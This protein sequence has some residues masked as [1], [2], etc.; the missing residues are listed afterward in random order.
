VS[1][2]PSYHDLHITTEKIPRTSIFNLPYNVDVICSRV[3]GW[4]VW[5]VSRGTHNERLVAGEFDLSWLV[6]DVAGHVIVDSRAAADLP[7]QGEPPPKCICF[8]QWLQRPNDPVVNHDPECP[9]SESPD[10]ECC[11][12]AESC[13]EPVVINEHGIMFAFDFFED[14]PEELDRAKAEGRAFMACAVC[15]DTC[16]AA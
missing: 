15:D 1:E 10:A 12:H 3:A 16:G 11:G 6:L 13:H 5:D 4:Q 7:V 2:A 14:I 8:R 9:M